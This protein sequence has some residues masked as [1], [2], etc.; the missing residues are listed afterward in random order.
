MMTIPGI[1]YGGCGA[2]LCLAVIGGCGRGPGEGF[3]GSA[4][5]ENRTFQV[6]ATVQGPLVAVRKDEGETV[7]RHEVIAVVDTVP[8]V[9]ELEELEARNRQLALKVSA[10]RAEITAVE[11]ELNGVKRELRRIEPLVAEGTVP[12]QRQDELRTRSESVAARLRAANLGVRGL[13]GER[14]VLQVRR[15]RIRDRLDRCYVRAPI[16]GYVMTRFRDRGEMAGP[17]FPVYE[18]GRNDSVYVDFY[19]PQPLMA[20]L[21]VGEPVTIRI[22]A[23]DSAVFAPATISWI[24]Q[25]AEFSP[26]NIQTRETRN[27][28][29]FQVRARAANAE[30]HL[31]RGLPVE[32]RRRIR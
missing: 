14:N 23:P 28:L 6:G 25:D 10:Q 20:A 3:L 8:L 26:K 32:V 4:V 29:V 27:E 18:L 19:V 12:E 30:G 16:D 21:R 17:G 22:D 31:K 2:A 13:E 5:V 11:A 24:A 7:A 15:R 1:R 9:L